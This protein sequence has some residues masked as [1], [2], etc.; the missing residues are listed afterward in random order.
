M[1]VKVYM[2]MSAC[3]AKMYDR[4]QAVSLLNGQTLGVF[5][6]LIGKRIKHLRLNF[7]LKLM[8]EVLRSYVRKPDDIKERNGD[9]RPASSQAL[10]HPDPADTFSTA[11]TKNLLWV[12]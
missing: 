8:D 4:V 11:D 1:S 5:I 2:Y 3:I 6:F 9:R 7:F 12:R 10:V